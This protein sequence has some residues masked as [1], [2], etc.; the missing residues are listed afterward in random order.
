MQKNAAYAVNC[1]MNGG[2]GQNQH[3]HSAQAFGSQAGTPARTN[4]QPANPVMDAFDQMHLDASD[5]GLPA[6]AA[7]WPV[8]LQ[9][10]VPEG[11][12]TLETGSGACIPHTPF[13]QPC[14]QGQQAAPPS[15]PM[16]LI[17]QPGAPHGAAAAGAWHRDNKAQLNTE[18]ES[19]LSHVVASLEST[20]GCDWPT[21][22]SRRALITSVRLMH[23][24][25]TT[26][27]CACPSC[28]C[29]HGQCQGAPY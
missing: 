28:C 25:H 17:R 22:V 18:L 29:A 13:N 26:A 16:Q 2:Q 7:V 6:G 14:M 20:S 8:E 27:V 1:M 19:I 11:A 24:E 15:T 10:R 9:E 21:Q 12:V 3:M 5:P 23:T 4:T